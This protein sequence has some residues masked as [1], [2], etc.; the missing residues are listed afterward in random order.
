VVL[1]LLL[2]LGVATTAPLTDREKQNRVVAVSQSDASLLSAAVSKASPDLL[3]VALTEADPAL[4]ETALTASE[5]DLLIAA[6]NNVDPDLLAV[7]LTKS[8]KNLL[9]TAL[10]EAKVELLRTALNAPTNAAILEVALTHSAPELLKI[11]LQDATVENLIVALTT[12]DGSAS[13]AFEKS[14]SA[15]LRI[16]NQANPVQAVGDPISA[17]SGKVDLSEKS[18]SNVVNTEKDEFPISK[19]F[20]KNTEVPNSKPAK[21]TENSEYSVSPL[22]FVNKYQV[23]LPKIQSDKKPTG[24]QPYGALSNSV[25]TRLGHKKDESV[26]HLKSYQQEAGQHNLGKPYGALSISVQTREG[27]KEKKSPQKTLNPYRQEVGRLNRRRLGQAEKKPQFYQYHPVTG[28][29][30]YSYSSGW[31]TARI[32]QD[33]VVRPVQTFPFY[34]SGQQHLPV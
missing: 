32:H 5:P 6:L 18:K 7:A 22:V 14:A 16:K 30:G 17:G 9:T 11:A 28:S 29:G 27:S 26:D 2:L 31:S 20:N 33:R 8:E 10:T 1:L 12:A 25:Q 23:P 4:L 19:A 21:H 24:G 3:R 34:V 15:N 13:T